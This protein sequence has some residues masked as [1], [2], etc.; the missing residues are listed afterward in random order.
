[1]F[2][3]Q[4]DCKIDQFFFTQYSDYKSIISKIKVDSHLLI[5]QVA[6]LSY[7]TLWTLCSHSHIHTLVLHSVPTM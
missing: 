4:H 5:C 2:I 3:Q 6:H 7:T 1:M